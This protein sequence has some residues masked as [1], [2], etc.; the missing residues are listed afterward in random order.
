MQTAGAALAVVP[1]IIVVL[2]LQR[3]FVQDIALTRMK[4]QASVEQATIRAYRPEDES[5]VVRIWNAALFADPINVT[6]WRAKVLLDPNFDPEGCHVAEIESKPVGFLLSLV[7]RV[8]FFGAGYEPG[9]AWMT[10]FAVDPDYQRHGAGTALLDAAL[11]RLKG[12]GVTTLSCSPYVPNYFTPGP[13]VSAYAVGIDLLQRRGFTEI[14]RPI[15]MRAELT[16]YQ[17]DATITERR[18][19][20]EADGVEIRPVTPLDIVPLLAFIR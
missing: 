15:S 12:M 10:A 1:I 7:R 19:E 13:D 20:L 2:M 14:E 8:P 11:A 18:K 16:G 17:E 6:T 3:S 4:D 5:E 9:Q